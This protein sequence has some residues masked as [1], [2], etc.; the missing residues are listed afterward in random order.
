MSQEAKMRSAGLKAVAI[1]ADTVASAK[2]CLFKTV[3]QDRDVSMVLLSPEQLQSK[4]YEKKLVNSSCFTERLCMIAVDE[5]HLLNTWGESFRKAFQQIGWT[6][7]RFQKRVPT[8]AVTAT[9]QVGTSTDRV[10]TFLGFEDPHCHV[11]RRSNYRPD[12]RLIVRTMKSGLENGDFSNR[13]RRRTLIFLKTVAAGFLVQAYFWRKLAGDSRRDNRVRMFNAVNHKAYNDETLAL[14]K[15][16][17]PDIQIIVA[18][19]ILS[20]GIDAPTFDDVIVYGQPP[21]TDEFIQ[22]YGRL[23]WG[24]SI[25][26]CAYL[27]LTKSAHTMATRVLG[28]SVDKGRSSD[29]DTMQPSMA[30]LILASCKVA[31]LDKLYGNVLNEQPCSCLTCQAQP[32]PLRKE[33]CDCSGCMPEPVQEQNTVELSDLDEEADKDQPETTVYPRNRLSKKMRDYGINTLTKWRK[34][35][36]K[37]ADDETQ[38]CLTPKAFLPDSVVKSILDVIFSLE[39]VADIAHL[40]K[41][42]QLCTHH[43]DNLLVIVQHIAERMEDIKAEGQAATRKSREVNAQKIVQ[44]KTEMQ[45]SGIRW[46]LSNQ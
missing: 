16:N 36:W 14:W 12:I 23:R 4:N 18:T 6:R 24:K 43:H 32:R 27:Y 5:A 7:A 28:T 38:G 29:R 17:H 11:I 39:T 8:A 35:I 45:R 40:T 13:G 22:D 19:S 42:T 30:S 33:T 26:P 9:L 44:A 41:D 37:A 3:A 10:R 31:A 21:D 25:S 34:D 20:V 46:V 2:S 15:A 1:N